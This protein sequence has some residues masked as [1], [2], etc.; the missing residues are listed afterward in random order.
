MSALRSFA[1]LS[2][3]RR[4]LL[5]TALTVTVVGRVGLATISF[6]RVASLLSWVP[7]TNGPSPTRADIHWAVVVASR[8]VPGTTCLE[9]ALTAQ[10]LCRRYGRPARLYVGVD[11][12]PDHGEFSAHSWVESEGSVLVGDEVDLGR[13]EP[14]GV[15]DQV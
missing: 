12:D 6:R 2:T 5:L 13:F 4:R 3:R 8:Q 10:T 15:V 7:T 1:E 14:L 9:R 11:R